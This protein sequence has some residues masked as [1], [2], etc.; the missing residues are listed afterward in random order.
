M[1]VLLSDLG[2][3]YQQV[4]DS[5]RKELLS[6]HYRSGEKLPSEADLVKRFGASR[7]T[8]GRAMRE[9]QN[10]DLIERRAGSGTYAR[11]A[12]SSGMT[13]GLLIPNLGQ[14]EIFEPICQGMADASQKGRHALL[15]GNASETSL[16]GHQ[17]L[18][19]CR[20]Y[21]ERRVSGIFFAPLEL[22]AEDGPINRQIIAELEKAR[23]PVVLLDRC[24]MP[25]PQR[26]R[27]DLVGVDNRSV[28][29]LAANHLLGLGCRRVAFLALPHSAST[30]E[31]R[32]A[33]Y[34]EALF[35]QGVNVEP[36]FVQRFDPRDRAAVTQF[37]ENEKPEAVVC[38]NDDT[39]GH[40]MH[41]LLALGHRIPEQ[42]RIVGIDD[43]R[44]ASMLPVPLTTVHQP[45]REIGVVAMSVMLDR[46]GN[47][48]LP[49]RDV[50]LQSHLVVRDSCGAKSAFT[51]E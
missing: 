23:I 35:L 16:R 12:S 39:A 26:S 11:S 25:Y 15:W 28:G 49:T 5:L 9:L 45:C 24:Y 43:L 1:N 13:F 22:T 51:R 47:P 4:L 17:A 46:V 18:Q 8:I 3:K 40:L 2:P 37:V 50:L 48:G 14:T 19:L 21:I 29:Y 44:F 27:Y 7:I 10:L 38:A 34:R 6:G 33:G 36:G 31:A 20:Q 32:I 30:A 42:I 41:S